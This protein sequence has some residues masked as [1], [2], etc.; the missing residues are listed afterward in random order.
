[1]TI[2][3]NLQCTHHNTRTKNFGVNQ[4][5][6]FRCF[7][8]SWQLTRNELT[9]I[10]FQL[11]RILAKRFNRK[12]HRLWKCTKIGITL[13]PWANWRRKNHHE[14]RY[15]YFSCFFLPWEGGKPVDNHVKYRLADH[16]FSGVLTF[17][18]ASASNGRKNNEVFGCKVHSPTRVK[19]SFSKDLCVSNQ[20][21]AILI[22]LLFPVKKLRK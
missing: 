12:I 11:F 9:E 1:M 19:F 7:F 16:N 10:K 5:S 18:S 22:F 4:D 6:K 17:L 20:D 8:D 21:V 2:C 15:V 13:W 14:L 3:E